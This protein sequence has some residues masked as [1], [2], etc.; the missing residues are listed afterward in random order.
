MEKLFSEENQLVTIVI[1]GTL[2]LL[3]ALTFLLILF[4][5]KKIV[6]K[7]LEKKKIEHQ[8]EI[9]YKTI[10]TQENERKR[11]AQ[12]LHDDISSKLNVVLLNSNFLI[13]GDL[14]HDEYNK[15]VGSIIK[16]TQEAL[17]S[18]RKIAYDLFPPILEKF[19]LKSAIEELTDHCNISKKVIF[20]SLIDYPENYLN[21][22]QELHVFR[23]IQELVNNSIQHGKAEKIHLN[24][25]EKRQE[26]ALYYSDNGIG[27]NRDEIDK[28]NG[29]GIKNIRSRVEILNGELI[30][31]SAINEGIEVSIIF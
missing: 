3:V 18:A 27:F 1:F 5:R 13:E 25:F 20:E 9:I 6:E 8:K 17:S 22:T 23:I 28:K 19:G 29:L 4:F 16:V 14:S 7:E 10:L 31:K 12:D 15:T 11:I 24:F 26:V 30:I 21:K 2:L